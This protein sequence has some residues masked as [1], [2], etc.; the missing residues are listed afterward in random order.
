MSDAEVG[1]ATGRA[2]WDRGVGDAHQ[3]ALLAVAALLG[4]AAIHAYMGASSL[5]WAV[6]SGGWMLPL[7][8]LVATL[9]PWLHLAT[10]V[11]FLRWLAT[12]V[13]VATRLQVSP[14]LPWT[15]RQACWSFFIPIVNLVRPYTVIRDLHDRLAPEGVPEPAP[16]PRIDGVGGYRRVEMEKA[17]PPARLPHAWIGAWWGS[18]LLGGLTANVTAWMLSARL[19]G[20]L[21]NGAEVTA[22]LLAVLAVRAIDGRLAERNRR[23]QH[24]TDEELAEWGVHP[25]ER[26]ARSG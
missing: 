5:V 4:M 15:S 10:I 3:G 9:Q 21:V 8:D 18:Y 12:S 14:R 17:P 1:A 19:E 20:F 13:R 22:A 11:F 26:P 16:R 2:V 6:T 24:A 7:G 23:L 25:G